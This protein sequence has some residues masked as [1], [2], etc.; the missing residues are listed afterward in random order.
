MGVDT[1]TI[2]EWV[3]RS[4]QHTEIDNPEWPEVEEAI[5]AL[6]NRCRNDVY[7]TPD[8]NDPETY[9]CIGGG[10]GRYIATGSIRNETFPTVV[11]TTKPRDVQE[12][13]VVGGQEG[14]FPRSYIIDLEMALRAAK[15][16]YESGTFG[17]G[18]NWEQV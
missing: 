3:A 10:D 17:T 9:L 1:L 7:L 4:V 2:C 14:L 8:K 18:V 13:L 15:V 6:D 12:R 16:F 5:R 11:D